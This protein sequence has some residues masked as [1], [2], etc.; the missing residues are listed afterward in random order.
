M[1]D[2]ILPSQPDD[3]IAQ[4]AA[5]TDETISEIGVACADIL[6]AL[7]IA[8]RR[9]LAAC[10][11]TL[12]DC[13]DAVRREIDVITGGQLEA[14]IE[15]RDSLRSQLFVRADEYFLQVG[16]NIPGLPSPEDVT[17]VQNTPFP[18]QPVSATPLPYQPDPVG[19]D[20]TCGLVAADGHAIDAP[21]F[22]QPTYRVEVDSW[23][24]FTAERVYNY[25]AEAETEAWIRGEYPTLPPTLPPGWKWVY[26]FQGTKCTAPPVG[27]EYYF[28]GY[29]A[30]IFISPTA[31]RDTNVTGPSGPQPPG[32]NDGPV[33]PDGN[34]NT[35]T[36]GT[37]G[38]PSPPGDT[39]NDSRIRD[40]CVQA[41]GIWDGTRC[42][43][44]PPL[45]PHNPPDGGLCSPVGENGVI[46]IVDSRGN[47]CAAH[48][49]A[50]NSDP[51]KSVVR[52]DGDARLLC[53][54]CLD[55]TFVI[56]DRRVNVSGNECRATCVPE[57]STPD[58][59]VL[60]LEVEAELYCGPC[61]KPSNNPVGIEQP[62]AYKF[63][64]RQQPWFR[65]MVDWY[66][67]SIIDF[68]NS[69]TMKDYLALIE[70]QRA[71]RHV[72]DDWS[73]S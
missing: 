66:G 26:T 32:I 58:R 43:F 35:G 11:G 59:Q 7:T 61:G 16:Y 70:S 62:G 48:C 9:Q 37:P 17:N 12:S 53:G 33:A 38:G 10:D 27:F 50:D 63:Q 29:Q 68:H 72:N 69:P 44:N 51:S 25:S 1:A 41:G 49:V 13:R 65:E 46:T 57:E 73:L 6:T 36:G 20:A 56:R 47:R 24:G 52:L 31:I 64:Q 19:T 55:T 4:V 21:R 39:C 71:A 30:G 5:L 40:A 60:L 42:H 23:P 54:P 14:S 2:A 45:Y 18:T 28:P 8:V 22:D 34:G 15:C 3:T 67:Q